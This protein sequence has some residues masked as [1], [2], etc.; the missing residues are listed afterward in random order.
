[1]STLEWISVAEQPP[2]ADDATTI[3]AN[4]WV[5]MVVFSTWVDGRLVEVG[6]RPIDAARKATHWVRIEDFPAPG[7][8]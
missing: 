7:G 5:P 1:M 4:L 8:A 2:A 3:A 6:V